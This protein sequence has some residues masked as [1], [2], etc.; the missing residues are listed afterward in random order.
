MH[1]YGG[2]ITQVTSEKAKS[3]WRRHRNLHLRPNMH[4]IKADSKKR[5]GLKL[6]KTKQVEPKEGEGREGVWNF[7][8]IL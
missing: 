1:H 5:K 8:A 4:I 3:T 6:K 2:K 7:F